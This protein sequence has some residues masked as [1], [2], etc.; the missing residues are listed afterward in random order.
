VHRRVKKRARL[1]CATLLTLAAAASA[2]SDVTSTFFGTIVASQDTANIAE[3][4]AGRSMLDG[5]EVRVVVAF[6][7]SRAPPDADPSPDIGR[8]TTRDARDAWLRL[9]SVEVGGRLMPTPQFDGSVT[10][11]D[12]EQHIL[13]TSSGDVHIFIDLDWEDEETGAYL[14]HA[15]RIGLD[16][17]AR[18]GDALVPLIGP[19]ASVRGVGSFSLHRIAPG[20]SLEAYL[21]FDFRLTGAANGA[22]RSGGARLTP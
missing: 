12:A 18:E 9:V 1:A 16:G 11:H 4:G 15:L 22:A 10:R 20:G 21:G 6:D 2:G 13:V 14:D 5:L 17:A 8:Y 7:P 3:R 19:D